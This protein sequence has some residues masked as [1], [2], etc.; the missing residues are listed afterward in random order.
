MSVKRQAGPEGAT[1][2]SAATAA[3]AGRWIYVSGQLPLDAHGRRVEGS[4]GEQTGACLD[5]V[6]DVLAKEGAGLVDV[7]RISAYLASLEDYKD[8][9]RVRGERFAGS[10]PASTA[11]GVAGLL[12]GAL[13]EIDAIAF[14]AGD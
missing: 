11:V 4:L 8:Y 10:F 5:R 2:S 9:S 14:V 7:V 3:G 1:Y 12:G 13:V 6:A